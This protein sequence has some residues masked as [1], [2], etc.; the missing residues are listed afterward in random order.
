MSAAQRILLEQLYR[1]LLSAVVVLARLLDK[2]CPVLTHE[3][4]RRIR[5]FVSLD[6]M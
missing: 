1:S 2:P 6:D 4:K 3:E 5:M